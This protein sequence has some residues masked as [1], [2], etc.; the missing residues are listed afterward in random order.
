M[1]MVW[2]ALIAGFAGVAGGA[3]ANR[4]RRK[5][6]GVNRQFQERMRNTQWQSAVTDMEAA[7]INPALAYS[8]GPAASPGGSMASQEDVV[9]PGISSA[10]AMRMQQKQLKVLEE[11]A[12]LK[13][14]QTIRE[15]WVGDQERV[16]ERFETARWQYYFNKDGTPRDSLRNVLHQEYGAKLANSAK[17]ISESR[18]S[19][20]S[21]PE[22]EALAKIF[23]Q[24]GS[25]GK[26]LQM[27]LPFL[28]SLMRR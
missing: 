21:I 16:K 15:K 12:N 24:V 10:M 4:S 1:I 19:A 8:Q 26:G 14:A 13:R 9:S 7:G 25:G 11:D 20:L 5:E 18:L 2:P 28:I 22:R 6:S 17:S 23:D 27:M 3:L